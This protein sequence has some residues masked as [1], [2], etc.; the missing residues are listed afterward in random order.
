MFDDDAPPPLIEAS[1]RPAVMASLAFVLVLIVATIGIGHHVAT[2]IKKNN[3]RIIASDAALY[4]ESIIGPLLQE[5]ANDDHLSEGPRRALR[6]IFNNTTVSERVVSFTLCKPGGLVVESSDPRLAGNYIKVSPRHSKA[7]RGETT[8]E[9]VTTIIEDDT[10][11]QEVPILNI[12]APIRE[13]YSGRIIAIIEFDEFREGIVDEMRD[14]SRFSYMAVVKTVVLIGSI[15]S[16]IVVLGWIKI[17]NQGDDIARLYLVISQKKEAIEKHA[18]DLEV[19][20]RDNTALGERLRESYIRSTENTEDTMRRIGA[21][22]HDGPAQLMSFAA[23]KLD[24]LRDFA[25]GPEADEDIL[26]VEQA[27][28]AAMVEIRAVSRG[29]SLPEIADKTLSDVIDRAVR[30]HEMRTGNVV[31]LQTDMEN[32]P[33][34]ATIGNICVF[35]FIQEALNNA[36]KHAQAGGFEVFARCDLDRFSVHVRDGGLG[37]DGKPESFG[38]GLAGLRNRIESLNGV[39]RIGRSERGGMELEFCYDF[40]NSEC[41]LKE[42]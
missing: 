40:E 17:R 34:L 20:L 7:W 29:L 19:A 38:L 33:I 25:M 36:H 31:K 27:I 22:L 32:N 3:L 11:R 30:E 12:I 14:I 21:D 13:I 23:L 35:R 2:M 28:S 26:S 39:F 5:L 4:M 6:E 15:L 42:L 24:G 37:F 41:T 9:L 18:H 10:G 16:I 1:L 8:I